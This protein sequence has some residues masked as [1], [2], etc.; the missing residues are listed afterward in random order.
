MAHMCMPTPKT[1]FWWE[2]D[3]SHLLDLKKGRLSPGTCDPRKPKESMS[4]P[5]RTTT[6]MIMTATDD[7]D[8]DGLDTTISRKK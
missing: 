4:I 7:I 8:D 5:A 3:L 6:L 1:L 2:Q